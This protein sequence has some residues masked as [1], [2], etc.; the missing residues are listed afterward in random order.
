M[1]VVLLWCGQLLG[2]PDFDGPG[3][4][5]ALGDALE[6]VCVLGQ[7]PP[8]DAEPDQRPHGGEVVVVMP[9][10]SASIVEPLSEPIR[11]QVAEVHHVGGGKPVHETGAEVLEVA[12]RGPGLHAIFDER[13]HGIGH[14]NI[15]EVQTM[16]VGEI[17]GGVHD[18]STPENGVSLRELGG[19]HFHRDSGGSDGLEDGGESG[20]IGST[21]PGGLGIPSE[22]GVGG[23]LRLRLGGIEGAEGFP[24][25]PLDGIQPGEGE[26]SL[27]SDRGRIVPGGEGAE[28]DGGG[29]S[30]GGGLALHTGII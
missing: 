19:R 4:G 11:G 5:L 12:L 21:K 9:R 29:F 14:G 24:D 17:A 28:R 2:G 23:T 27:A 15:W 22:K 16:L 25:P 7:P 13:G 1:C 18:K 6:K 20:A 10:S 8:A 30:W 3:V 26:P